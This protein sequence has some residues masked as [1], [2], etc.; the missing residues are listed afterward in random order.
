MMGVYMETTDW[1]FVNADRAQQLFPNQ[2]LHKTACWIAALHPRALEYMEQAPIIA[3]AA[4][5]GGKADSKQERAYLAMNLKPMFD[6][7]DKLKDVMKAFKLPLPLRGISAKALRPGVW[8]VLKAI[9][10][11]VAPQTIGQTIPADPSKHLHWLGGLAQLWA[12]IERRAAGHEGNAA[13]LAWAMKHGN[14]FQSGIVARTFEMDQIGDFLICERDRWNA[15]WS[16]KRVV[17]ETA[18][19]HSALA[20]AQIDRLQY[21]TYDQEV[22]Y[23]HFPR[24]AEYSGF[25][26]HSL[27]SLRALI[28]EG[29]AMSHCIASYM[30]DIRTGRS[31]LYSVRKD[32][33]RVA[34][35]ELSEFATGDYAFDT[36][37][38]VRQYRPSAPRRGPSVHVRQLKGFANAVVPEDVKAACKWLA[39]DTA[40]II[41][42]AKSK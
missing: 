37:G 2:G 27:Q 41:R 16:W 35:L 12:V 9:A 25:T 1:V 38:R 18:D 23:G 3:L 8:D 24:E 42:K 19:W 32:G 40:T 6:R 30:P 4:S 36:P 31:R 39:S 28:V 14:E 34:T 17:R 29:R 13:I 22:D 33:Q 20:N 11:H 5:F 7:G 15:R 10:T 26:F 21:G